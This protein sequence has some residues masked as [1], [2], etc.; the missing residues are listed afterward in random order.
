MKEK[1]NINFQKGL[2]EEQKAKLR[3]QLSKGRK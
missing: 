3:E 2:T 1:E